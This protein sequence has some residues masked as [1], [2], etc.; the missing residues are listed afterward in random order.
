MKNNFFIENL[1]SWGDNAPQFCEPHEWKSIAMETLEK[2]KQKLGEI[3]D[4]LR[5]DTL[6]PAQ[7]EALQIVESAKA[8]SQTIVDNAKREA[9]QIV[10]AAQKQIEQ[11][12]VLFYSSMDVASKQAFDKLREDIELKL[13]NQELNSLIHQISEDPQRIAQLVNV[14][15]EVIEREGLYGNLSLGLSKSIQPQEISKYLMKELTDKLN[16]NEI[17]IETISGGASVHLKDKAISID[18]SDQALKELF[19]NF[20]RNSFREILFKNV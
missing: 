7:K 19:G 18:I 8:E 5:K 10:A 14:V 17:P 4:L 13:F 2:G 3:C 6:E 15:V 11:E 1:V 12:K 20:L 16:K 9:Q